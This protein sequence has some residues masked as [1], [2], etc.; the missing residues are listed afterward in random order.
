MSLALPCKVVNGD[1]EESA[2]LFKAKQACLLADFVC[3]EGFQFGPGVCLMGGAVR[4]HNLTQDQDIVL[5]SDWVWGDTDRAAG[6]QHANDWCSRHTKASSCMY[7]ILC[8]SGKLQSTLLQA[9][10][11]TILGAAMPN[12]VV[13]RTAQALQRIVWSKGYHFALPTT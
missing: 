2:C 6:T 5:A 7:Q 4:I 1:A 3:D 10:M 13:C 9:R 11:S 12:M 8:Q